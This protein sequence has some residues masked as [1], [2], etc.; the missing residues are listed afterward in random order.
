MPRYPFSRTAR[1]APRSFSGSRNRPRTAG[2]RYLSGMDFLHGLGLADRMQ[3]HA[4]H[5]RYGD[6]R[7]EAREQ[8]EHG[9]EQPERADEGSDIPSGGGEVAPVARQEVL[10]QRR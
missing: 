3:Q 10:R 5:F 7:H 6:D 1:M 9:E 8:H 2:G 4:L